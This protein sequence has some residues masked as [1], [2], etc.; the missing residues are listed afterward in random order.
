SVRL[1]GYLRWVPRHVS[2]PALVMLA[3][4]DRIIQ[5]A[6]TRAYVDRFATTD[7]KVIEYAGAHHTLEFEPDPDRWLEDLL[8]WLRARDG[9]LYHVVDRDLNTPGNWRAILQLKLKNLKTGNVTQKRVRPDD[10][11]ETAYLEKRE[12]EYIYQE[13]SGYVFMD[14]ETYD[15]ITL[16]EMVG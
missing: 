9:Q 5:N 7:K 8:G 6:P 1:G 11:V 3:E 13:A 4:H 15:Q 14:T 2:V 10:K 12:M 16:Q